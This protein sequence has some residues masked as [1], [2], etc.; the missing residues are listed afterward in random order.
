ME[1]KEPRPQAQWGAA[2]R[3]YWKTNGGGLLVGV[4][5][6]RDPFVFAHV[7]LTKTLGVRRAKDIQVRITRWMDL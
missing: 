4:D 1:R 6:L 2:S 7:V 3:K 5:S